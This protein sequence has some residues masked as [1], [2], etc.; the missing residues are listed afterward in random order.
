MVTSILYPRIPNKLKKRTLIM[1]GCFGCAYGNLML[2]PTNLLYFPD[3]VIIQI[4]GLIGIS[5]PCFMLI[6]AA[7]PEMIEEAKPLYPYST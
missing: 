1:I 3:K 2:G 5:V 7:L 4:V 6:N